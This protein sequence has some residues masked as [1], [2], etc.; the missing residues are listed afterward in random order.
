MWEA[1]MVQQLL[2]NPAFHAVGSAVA[3]DCIADAMRTYHNPSYTPP[4][5][6]TSYSW[7]AAT[8]QVVKEEL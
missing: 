3:K 4:P 7:N 2:A 1:Y 6:I 5:T 8:Q